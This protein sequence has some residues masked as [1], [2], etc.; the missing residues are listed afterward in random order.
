MSLPRLTNARVHKLKRLLNMQ[1][2]LTELAG[3]LG[4]TTDTIY[5]SYIPAG[6]P[7]TKDERGH[8]WVNGKAFYEWAMAYVTTRDRKPK[9]PMDPD[10]AYCMRCNQVI[11][12]VN[13]R[14]Y[15][16]NFSGIAK[17]TGRCPVCEGKVSRFIRKEA[18]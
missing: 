5:R 6:M 8:Y 14:V 2:K 13:K 3:E 9:K 15:Q 7:C 10:Q 18:E 4:I 17:V 11:R 1:Y 12:I 16:A